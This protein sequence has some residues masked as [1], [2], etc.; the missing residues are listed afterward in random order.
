M[1]QFPAYTILD[2]VVDGI[3]LLA[4]VVN[5]NMLEC[6]FQAHLVIL[7]FLVAVEHDHFLSDI[8]PHLR[9]LIRAYERNNVS[10]PALHFH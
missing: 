3:A 1:R 5:A 10:V 6:G 2:K 4:R 8:S 9:Q 7:V